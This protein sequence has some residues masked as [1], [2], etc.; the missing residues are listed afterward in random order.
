[1][2]AATTEE[3]RAALLDQI[4]LRRMGRPEEIAA[5]TLF[6]LSDDASYIAGAELCVDGGMRQV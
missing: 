4:P 6:L 1:M 3:M 5:A 2:M